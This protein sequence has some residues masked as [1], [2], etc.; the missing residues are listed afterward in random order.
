MGSAFWVDWQERVHG[1]CRADIEC[2]QQ[3]ISAQTRKRI[4]GHA[5]QRRMGTFGGTVHVMD[6]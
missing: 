2:T 3:Q 1:Q 5:H 6:C 4:A